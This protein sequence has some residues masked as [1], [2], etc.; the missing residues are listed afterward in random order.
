MLAVG[1][2]GVTIYKGKNIHLRAFVMD[3]HVHT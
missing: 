2:Q 3:S 1:L